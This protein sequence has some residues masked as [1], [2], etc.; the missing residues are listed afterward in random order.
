MLCPMRRRTYPHRSSVPEPRPVLLAAARAFVRAASKIDGVRRIA[1]VGS[2]VTDKPMPKDADM[3][4]TIDP[5]IELD[6]LARTGRQLKGSAQTINC[7]ADIFLADPD[8]NYLGRICGYRE[9]H[10]RVRCEARH[11]G[12]RD[13][14]NDDLDVVTLS[15]KLIAE[16]PLELWPAVVRRIALPADV[17]TILLAAEQA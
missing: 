1:L 12:V 3:L 7:G 17:E 10:A 13:H 4:V 5:A 2:L 15:R 14:L 8:D 9:C 16:P 11:C 6:A